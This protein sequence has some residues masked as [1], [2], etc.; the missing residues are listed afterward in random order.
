MFV[1]VPTT[2]LDANTIRFIAES[3]NAMLE[4]RAAEQTTR[5]ERA[6]GARRHAPIGARPTALPVN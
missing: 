4:A 1:L 6:N 5:D 2:P 3:T